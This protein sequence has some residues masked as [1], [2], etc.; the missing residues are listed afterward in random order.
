MMKSRQRRSNLLRRI[1]PNIK[2]VKRDDKM[3]R[4]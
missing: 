2:K 4:R 1:A 3:K